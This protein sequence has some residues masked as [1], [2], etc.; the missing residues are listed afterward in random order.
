V[1]ELQLAG[2]REEDVDN[3]PLGGREQHLLDKLLVL[4]ATAVGADELHARAG[5]GDVEDAGVRRV[6]Q[7]E[8][9][10]LAGRGVQPELRLAGNEHHVAETAHGDV[11]RLRPER[12]QLPVLEQEVVE[13]E[14]ELAVG[15]RPVAGLGGVDEDV[16][17]E[18]QLLAVVLADVRVVPVDAGV[19]AVDV[20]RERVADRNRR[21]RFMRPVV[22]VLEPET[23]P[24]N[25]RL[26]LGVVGDVHDHG[27]A[28]RDLERWA[29][30][31]AVVGEH[32]N[33][34]LAEMLRDRS[35]LEIEGLTVR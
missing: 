22:A 19:G 12:R 27:R 30:N 21:L 29:W 16:A 32:S 7:E 1:L 15:G 23:V 28:L 10:D 34:R 4:V 20:V 8:A 14:Q 6:G 35:D 31:G 5:Q 9:D 26:H 13:R 18:A 33:G 17:V 2:L 3:D 25:G 11:R 24:V